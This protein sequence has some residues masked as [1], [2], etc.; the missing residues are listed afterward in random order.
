[1][2]SASARATALISGAPGGGAGAG[3]PAGGHSELRSGPEV[4]VG[5]RLGRQE[6]A[7]EVFLDPSPAQ[8]CCSEAGGAE[9]PGDEKRRTPNQ[10]ARD[11]D[12][13][14]DCPRKP[15]RSQGTQSDQH[16]A[17]AVG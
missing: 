5:E 13:A 7:G 2:S 1:M 4:L 16:I 17:I 9:K 11:G 10:A 14:E 15:E 8:E 12:P 3:S 6:P